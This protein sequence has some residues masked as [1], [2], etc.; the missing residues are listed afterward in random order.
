MA[1][2]TYAHIEF[3]PDGV[4]Y[5]SGTRT[6]VL[7][8]ALDRIA[9][10]WDADEILRQHPQLNLGQIYS[11]LSYYADHQEELDRQIEEQVRLVESSRAAAGESPIRVKLK[12]M[13]RIP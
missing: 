11:A 1:S 10:H 6:K 12:A 2:V 8:I 4:A 7:E 3:A 9:H 5:I 13:G